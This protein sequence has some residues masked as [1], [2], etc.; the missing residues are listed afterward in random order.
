MAEPKLPVVKHRAAPKS[1][2]D[3]QRPSEWVRYRTGMCEGC[4]SGCC[5]LPLEASLGDL[6]RLELVSEEE[7]SST[8]P[9]KIAKRLFDGGWI[10]AFTSKSQIFVIAQRFGRDCIFLDADR[11]CT[12]YDKRPE[13]CRRFPR[14]GPRPG[15]CPSAKK[16]I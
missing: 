5:T 16:V 4:W 7:A 12:V 11:R 15:Y 10:Q 6:V 8:A 13:V 3:A 1:G 9:K 14:I 2:P